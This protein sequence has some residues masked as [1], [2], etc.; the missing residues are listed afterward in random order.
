[1]ETKSPYWVFPAVEQLVTLFYYLVLAALALFAIMS[2]LKLLNAQTS[3]F[4][5]GQQEPNYV[6]VP[7]AWA[8]PDDK[9]IATAGEPQLFLTPQ[10][11]TGQ[12]QV[13]IR[14]VPG[15]L[16]S[17]LELVGLVAA[18]WM[19]FLLR[20]IFRSVQTDSP[21]RA[22]TAR[23]IAT[24]GLLFLGQTAIELLLKLALW[25]QTRPYFSQIRLTNQASLSVNIQ[26]DGPWLLGLILL[27]LAQV[28]RRGIDIQLENE[29]TV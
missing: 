1:M 15:L 22:A 4:S 26:L 23:R 20:Q 9:T 24:M 7:V 5:L 18:A 21:F 17:L 6:S 16:M 14:S 13:P 19:F 2:S 12:L 27:A 25:Q 29:L 10:K 11:Q 28:Y 8:L 3:S